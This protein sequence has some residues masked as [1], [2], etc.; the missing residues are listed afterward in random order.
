MKTPLHHPRGTSPVLPE[1]GRSC[2]GH[3]AAIC[4]LSFLL[5]LVARPAVAEVSEPDNLLYGT[6]V[7]GSDFVTAGRTDVVVEARRTPTGP[8]IARYRMGSNRAAGDFYALR[9]PVEAFGPLAQTNASLA[10]QTLNIVVT[11]AAGVQ[12]QG[13]YTIPERGRVQRVDFGV[14]VFDS[15]NNGLPDAWELAW[16]G[17]IGQ[18]PNGDPDGDGQ[19]TGGE[20][21]SG[22][23]PLDGN[24]QFRLSVNLGGGV[25]EVSFVALRAEGS[26]YEGRTRHYSLESSTNLALG[27]WTG[28]TGLTNVTGNN[29]TMV[30]RVPSG[31]S[32]K[33]FYRGNV[34]L[35]NP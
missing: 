32:P 27:S 17:S 18:D 8:A 3:C 28:V 30:L 31:N 6:I 34:T 15:D 26:G 11:D 4:A 35:T 25:T 24:D 21:I 2:L 9:I 12:G 20:W 33:N 13:T 14:P 7:I 22:T 1:E 19:S 5:S 10:G 29:Q 23:D 16:F